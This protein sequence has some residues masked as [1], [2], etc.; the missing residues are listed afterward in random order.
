MQQKGQE[1]STQCGKQTGRGEERGDEEKINMIY[2]E[3]VHISASEENNGVSGDG[4]LSE[5][6]NGG[7]R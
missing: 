6:R 5:R 7:Q 1:H 2:K 4:W 3:R